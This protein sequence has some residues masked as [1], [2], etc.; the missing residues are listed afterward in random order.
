MI[1]R[2]Y[3]CSF[4]QLARDGKLKNAKT[5]ARVWRRIMPH[6]KIHI[7]RGCVVYAY[8]RHLNET[9]AMIEF[10]QKVKQRRKEMQDEREK[11]DTEQPTN[12]E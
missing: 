9:L 5:I 1:N 6:A 8:S 10:A 11:L 4:R 7:R 2:I 3:T 12:G